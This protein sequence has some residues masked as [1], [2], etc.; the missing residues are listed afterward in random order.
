MAKAPAFDNHVNIFSPKN[1][2]SEV[3]AAISKI[4]FTGVPYFLCFLARN[5][6]SIPSSAIAQMAWLHPT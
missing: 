6:G 4:A 1:G 2:A 5:D 3:T